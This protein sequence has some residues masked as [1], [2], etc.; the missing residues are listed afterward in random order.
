MLP[1]GRAPS[2]GRLADDL[3]VA[4]DALGIDR[5]S[6]VGWSNGGIGALAFAARHPHRVTRAVVTGAPAPH[7]EVPWIPEQFVGFLDQL[8]QMPST[9]VGALAPMLGVSDPAE[10]IAQM[11]GGVDDEQALTEPGVRSTL[12]AMLVEAYRQGGT[13]VAADIVATN[14]VPWGFDLAA[15]QSRVTLLYG[16]S[17]AIVP[18]AHG[19]WY[20][21][22]LADAELEVV[23]GT[24]HLLPLTHW[25]RLLEATR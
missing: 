12:E 6:V 10:A 24:G 23:E 19:A 9:A 17:D 14:V 21:A 8:R 18:S 20:V 4:L 2:W 15:V 16:G 3:A 5:V 13:G 25:G 7:E 22:R 1:A 11:G